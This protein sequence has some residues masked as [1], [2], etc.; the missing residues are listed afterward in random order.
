MNQNIIISLTPKEFKELVKECLKESNMAPSQKNEVRL[1]QKEASSYLGISQTTIID[2]K[3]RGLIPFHQIPNT[4]KIYY[5][6]SELATAARQMA[7]S[8]KEAAL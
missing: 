8:R 1:N 5:I 3:K 2:W 7:E 4:R 6:K